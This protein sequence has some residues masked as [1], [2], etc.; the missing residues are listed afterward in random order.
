MAKGFNSFWNINIYCKPLELK[1]TGF[2]QA[3]M[4]ARKLLNANVSK[5]AAFC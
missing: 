4:L 2:D 1:N 3:F 5:W